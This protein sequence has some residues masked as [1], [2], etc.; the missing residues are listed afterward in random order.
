MGGGREVQT[1][2]FICGEVTLLSNTGVFLHNFCLRS[3]DRPLVNGEPTLS[4]QYAFEEQHQC[5]KME[6]N[7]EC[8]RVP[9]LLYSRRVGD[10]PVMNRSYARHR[11]H[12]LWIEKGGETKTKQTTDRVRAYY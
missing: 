5:E 12:L 1:G 11:P 3:R 4:I 10:G 6:I 9:L 7:L 8:N 2:M